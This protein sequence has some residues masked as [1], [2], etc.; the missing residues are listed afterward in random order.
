MLQGPG[1]SW[2]WLLGEHW[3]E[4]VTLTLV[5]GVEVHGI[6]R[7][8]NGMTAET[9]MAYRVESLDSS[10]STWVAARSI[11]AVEVVPS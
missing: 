6:L 9:T 8:A 2:L 4:E 7:H 10:R 11:V 3:D 5:C 1:S